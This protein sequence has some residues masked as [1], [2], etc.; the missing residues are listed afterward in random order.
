MRRVTDKATLAAAV[1]RLKE[2][3][4]GLPSG[5]YAL[6]QKTLGFHKS[7]LTIMAAR[8]SMGKTAMMTR[9]AL[10]QAASGLKVAVFSLEMSTHMMLLRMLAA[11]SKV[12]LSAL[13]KNMLCDEDRQKVRKAL[14]ELQNLDILMD[15]RS[16]LTTDEI[17]T[18]VQEHSPDIVY[19]DYLQLLVPK[20]LTASRYQ[21]VDNFCRELKDLAKS[22]DIPVIVLAQLNR[23]VEKRQIHEPRISDI[24][25]SGGIEQTADL[26][27]L[28]HRPAYYALYE[29]QEDN[30]D[31]GEAFIY[32]AKN[33]NGPT[34]KVPCCWIGDWCTYLPVPPT[35][36]EFGE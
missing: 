24:R 27:L 6:D 8:S 1:A 23:E 18:A 20:G 7:E 28:L 14:S 35:V 17:V 31:D 10:E 3:S 29:E 5:F 4:M 15:D 22:C 11:Y 13:R 16:A 25:E 33:R 34:G 36:A 2:S 12:S 26:V 30:I 19:V 21:E 9:M 32:V